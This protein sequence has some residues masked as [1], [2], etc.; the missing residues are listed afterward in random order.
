M[1]MKRKEIYWAQNSQITWLKEGD[2][3]PKFFHGVATNKRRKKIITSIEVGGHAVNDPYQIRNEAK[4]F[5][6]KIFRE[7]Y[8]NRPILENLQFNQLSQAQED[9]LIIPF[10]KDEIDSAVA[11][12]DSDKALGPDRFNFKFMKNAW[13]I[14]KN[15]I[16]ETVNEFWAS[17]RLPRGCNTPYITLISKIDHPPPC[18]KDYRPISMVGCCNYKIVAKLMAKRLQMVISTL[19]GP[20]QFSYIEGR[21]ILDGTLVASEIIESCKR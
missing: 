15:D 7:E 10:S 13:E 21:K 5:F 1:W 14:I 19:I 9:S 17:S 3:N 11:S 12:C 16:Y 18:F 8:A 6:K 2:R 4:T 20:F